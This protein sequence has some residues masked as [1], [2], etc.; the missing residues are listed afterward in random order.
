MVRT[1]L[2]ARKCT[3]GRLPA[4]RARDRFY[5]YYL[6]E[7]QE[8]VTFLLE[9][10]NRWAVASEYGVTGFEGLVQLTEVLPDEWKP[11]VES[12]VPDFVVPDSDW[13]TPEEADF[14][15]L[16]DVIIDQYRIARGPPDSPPHAVH[17][18]DV[19]F[20]MINEPDPI[21]DT[22][23][24][25]DSNSTPSLS[26]LSPVLEPLLVDPENPFDIEISSTDSDLYG[27][28]FVLDT[29][30]LLDVSTPP[31]V[32]SLFSSLLAEFEVGP[33]RPPGVTRN[34]KYDP[35]FVVPMGTTHLQPLSL[36]EVPFCHRF[37]Y[38]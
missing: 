19:E 25:V 35:E 11:W 1:R 20:M 28:P 7:Q 38:S 29:L 23:S 13:D 33:S 21:P 8:F 4:V 34:R 24:V 22:A 36:S 16:I 27:Q 32:V 15:G 37:I 6:D 12:I 26:D 17:P 10:Y 31:T 3:F 9:F 2:T 18:E 14:Q 5:S 30:S